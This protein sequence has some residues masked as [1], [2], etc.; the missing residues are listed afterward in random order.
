MKRFD[1]RYPAIG[2]W[3]RAMACAALALASLSVSAEPRFGFDTEVA[4]SPPAGWRV[5]ATNPDGPLATWRVAR[6]ASAPSAPQVLVLTNIQNNSGGV[7]NLCWNDTIAFRDGT[8]EA[9]VRADSGAEDQGGG[10]LWRARDANNYY[11]ARYN[12]LEHNLRLY[13]VRD[14]KRKQ[15]ASA[16]DLGIA[17]NTWFRIRIEQQGDAIEVSLDGRKLLSISDT[18]FPASG[19]VGFWTKADAASSFDDLAITLKEEQ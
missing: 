6:D 7:F 15:L 16:E 9:S 5:A 12:P 4:G 11:I 3:P 19:G 13:S 14:G 1:S 8:I 10:L 18:T 2:P 17:T